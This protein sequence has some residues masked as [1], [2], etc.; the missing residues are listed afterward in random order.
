[1][2]DRVVVSLREL[3][4]PGN[5]TIP[6][7]RHIRQFYELLRKQNLLNL[8]LELVS[9][10]NTLPKTRQVELPFDCLVNLLREVNKRT[11]L[12]FIQLW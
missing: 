5:H 4:N 6:F 8:V 1:M 9:C 7:L 10:W 11:D 3:Y 12:I 2:Q